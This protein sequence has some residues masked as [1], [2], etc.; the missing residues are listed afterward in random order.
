MPLKET[1]NTVTVGSICF[2]CALF[3]TAQCP[4]K[5]HLREGRVSTFRGDI[6]G[7]CHYFISIAEASGERDMKREAS[8]LQ[9]AQLNVELYQKM[10]KLTEKQRG[11]MFEYWDKIYPSDYAEDMVTDENETKKWTQHPNMVKL[12]KDNK[13]NKDKDK[14]GK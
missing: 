14:K 10:A 8:I 12:D 1:P 3:A 7:K 6:R 13:K 4:F 2:S 11:K 5:N 9:E